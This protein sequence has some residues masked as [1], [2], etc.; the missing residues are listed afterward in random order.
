MI[1]GG[2]NYSFNSEI[3]DKCVSA[4]F[5]IYGV[6][7][8]S[9]TENVIF[10]NT[11]EY[12][13][14]VYYYG[15]ET[16]DETNLANTIL[17]DVREN[18]DPSDEDGDHIPDYYEINGM[19]CL[20]GNIL[21]SDPTTA[22]TDG[23]GALDGKEAVFMR[24]TNEVYI[25][26]DTYVLLN[27]FIEKSDPQVDDTD[28]DGLNDL[29][30]PLPMINNYKEVNLQNI[31][32]GIEYLNVESIDGVTAAG[33]NQSWWRGLYNYPYTPEKVWDYYKES[34]EYRMDM[35]GCGVIAFTDLEL[36]FSSQNPGYFNPYNPIVIDYGNNGFISWDEYKR[37]AE[38]NRDNIYT[39]DVDPTHF[40]FGVWNGMA[41]GVMSY[42]RSNGY[43]FTT[44]RWAP[45]FVSPDK[46]ELTLDIIKRMISANIPVVFSY[47]DDSTR[48]KIYKSR[49]SYTDYNRV[50]SGSFDSSMGDDAVLS[51]Y[52][53]IIGYV[54]YYTQDGLVPKYLLKV[55][56]W[57][58]IYYIDY[59]EYSYKLTLFSNILEIE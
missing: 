51:H 40:T 16:K 58:R 10:K 1:I 24:K 22:N 36:Y 46:K 47:H 35:D 8:S 26:K 34:P 20:N 56:S 29:I 45:H 39:L 44:A 18:Y 28:G 32:G 52:M 55:V 57:G 30:D 42:L 33:G 2:G 13:G 43:P 23:D 21:Y 50:L 7:I 4:G 11:S 27:V 14:G 37:Y 12:T 38:Y 5:E 3:L 41:G 53:T 54:E 9:S 6:D 25:G 31:Y 19:Y 59:D 49:N 17:R 48:L 15:D